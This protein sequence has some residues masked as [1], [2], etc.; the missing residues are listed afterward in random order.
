MK[1]QCRPIDPIVREGQRQCD[2]CGALYWLDQR[3]D[4]PIVAVRVINHTPHADGSFEEF[5]LRVPPSMQTAREA[6]AWTFGLS[7]EEYDPVLES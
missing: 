2:R 6:V 7:P 1:T 4:E 3:F 5:W